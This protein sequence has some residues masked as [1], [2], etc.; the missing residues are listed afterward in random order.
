MQITVHQHLRSPGV[1]RWLD[2]LDRA[3]LR[4]G[5]PQAPAPT[6]LEL[7]S[8]AGYPL[9]AAVWSPT[10]PGPHPT[11]VLVP[12]HGAEGAAVGA[13]HSPIQPGEL[14]A[15]GIRCATLD[16]AGR[17]QSW[18]EDDFGGPEHQDDVAQ[19]V[20][21]LVG[22]ARG[23]RVGLIG[24]GGGNQA[25]LGAARR[26]AGAVP[27]VIDWEG[28]ADAETTRSLYGEDSPPLGVDDARWWSTRAAVAQIPALPCGYVRLQAEEDHRKLGEL[29]HALRCLHAAADGRPAWFQIN[30][31]PRGERPLRP[32]WIGRGLLPARAALLQKIR[33]LCAAG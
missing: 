27:W 18:G 3:A 5:R 2:R 29:R 12:D 19:L 9:H 23:G 7:R 20:A 25:A 24:L 26:L 14:T 32:V 33:T 1:D 13:P 8:A 21:A 31:H 30:D 16:L 6:K 4:L 22:Q 15:A 17:G 11:V 28:P 10:G